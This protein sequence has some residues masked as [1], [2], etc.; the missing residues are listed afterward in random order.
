MKSMPFSVAMCV[1]GGDHAGYFQIAVDSVLNQSIKPSEVVLVVD[2]PIPEA[3]E[4]IVAEYEKQPIFKVI[5][6]EK[7]QGHG[8]ARRTGL[9]NCS[10]DVVALMDADDVS[11]PCRFEKQLEVL[12]TDPDVAIV[13]GNIAEFVDTPDHVVGYRNVP[14]DDPSI[15]QYIKKR[16]PMNQVTVMFRKDAVEKV[17][18]YRDWY[19]NEDYYLW[20]RMFLADMKFANV[21]EVLV[22]VRVGR[23]MYQR[24]GGSKYFQSEAKL[25][26]YMLDN[27]IIRIP[28]YI[29]NIGKRFVVQVLLPNRLRSWVFRKLARTQK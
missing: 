1:Y 13:G 16:C 28:T 15:K 27:R 2:G 5:R 6:L 17:G 25:Q 11:L 21:P 18:G 14:C 24:R 20:L 9:A 12:K 26:K 10:F 23:E 3:L 19:C 7:N 4:R 22:N 29:M 8:I